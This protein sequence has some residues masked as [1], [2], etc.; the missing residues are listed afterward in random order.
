MY[1]T[2]SSAMEEGDNSDAKSGFWK[3][4]SNGFLS[5]IAEGT[6]VGDC[7]ESCLNAKDHRGDRHPYGWYGGC[8]LSLKEAVCGTMPCLG[9]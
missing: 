9:S 6:M 7:R 3:I 8:G 5:I 1:V 4:A 2:G